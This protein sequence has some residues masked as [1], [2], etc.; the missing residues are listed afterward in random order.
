MWR[1]GALGAT[2][3]FMSLALA[4]PAWAARGLSWSP[5]E[6]LGS[7]AVAGIS[8]PTVSL[9]VAIDGSNVLVA[10]PSARHGISWRR[11][12][13]AAG[14]ALNSVSCPSSGFCLAT[15]AGSAINQTTLLSSTHPG[16]RGARWRQVKLNHVRLVS[17]S[18]PS[19]S[20]CAAVGSAFLDGSEPGYVAFSRHPGGPAK[21]WHL[22]R[23]ATSPA[24][25]CPQIGEC[26]NELSAIACP[27]KSLCAAVDTA[28]E[29]ISSRNPAGRP[30][31]WRV[32]QV[33]GSGP[34]ST[35]ALRAIS[36]PSV[37]FCLAVDNVGKALSTRH[38]AGGA[39]GWSS[40]QVES[41]TRQC[42]GHYGSS[43]CPDELISV[44][45][46]SARFCLAGDQAGEVFSSAW[47][48]GSSSAWSST[49]IDQGDWVTSLSCPSSRLCLAG[50]IRGNIFR[51]TRRGR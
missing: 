30:Q 29:V 7:S 20:F 19:A 43:A 12:A 11:V 26:P 2:A 35:F 50:D 48:A 10:D 28:G 37:S 36:C 44:S 51:G 9:C 31:A 32:R 45:C 21:E 47:P 27:S 6:H 23:L 4:G 49:N 3:V 40:I 1:R 5:P 16:R 34:P 41:K 46:A 42:P 14:V 18:C 24:A 15:G 8:C 38:P 39:H 22:T 13:S 17:V 25:N 33:D